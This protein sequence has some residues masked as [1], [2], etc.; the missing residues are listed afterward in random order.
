MFMM[1]DGLTPS[2]K[3]RKP[4]AMGL[5]AKVLYLGL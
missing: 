1:N 5:P 2:G 3:F 4:Y